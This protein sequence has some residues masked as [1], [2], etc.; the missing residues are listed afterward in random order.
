MGK[1][2]AEGYS[3]SSALDAALD[4]AENLGQ[5]AGI[6]EAA[7]FMCLY[8]KAGY[9]SDYRGQSQWGHVEN[10]VILDCF[11]PKIRNRIAELE[12][13]DETHPL[14]ESEV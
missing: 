1:S 2:I 5:L 10:G 4:D 13:K 11:C 3:V 9:D 8:C 7:G 6:R 14:P 12:K